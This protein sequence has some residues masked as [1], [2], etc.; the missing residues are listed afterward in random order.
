M[1]DPPEATPIASRRFGDAIVTL[2]CEGTFPWNLEL[3][4]PEAAWRRAMPEADAGGAIMLGINVAH[5]RLGD[6]SILVDPGFDDPS[7]V[8]SPHFPGLVRSAGLLAGLRAIGVVPGQITH[9]LITH[10]HDDHFAGVTTMRDG[11][12][13]AR[14]PQA[15]HVVGRPDWEGNADRERPDSALAVH[16]GTLDRLGLLTPVEGEQEVAPGVTMVAAPGES[17]GHCIVRVE[18]GGE[19]CYI[20]GDLFH[21]ACEVAHPDWVSPGRDLH[22]MRAS[23]ERLSADA[24]ARQATVVFTHAP[25][26]GWG[27]IVRDGTGY[28]WERG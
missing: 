14:F 8:P 26:P 23:R 15:R 19:V 12:R 6:A 25:F 10:T 20:V 3:Q 5:I 1:A 27:R 17:P 4:A 28:R 16:L 22:A 2:I 21:H 7:A 24:V 18:R 13:V 11:R 9:V